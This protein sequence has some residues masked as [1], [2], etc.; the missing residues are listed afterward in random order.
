MIALL[1]ENA[2]TQNRTY[3]YSFFYDDCATRPRDKVEESMLGEVVYPTLSSDSKPKT[4]RDIIYESTINNLWARFGMDFCVGSEADRPITDRQLMFA[5][6]YLMNAFEGAQIATDS[7]SR[8][9]VSKKSQLIFADKE[10]LEYT[11]S[12][13]LIDIF[14]PMRCALILFIIVTLLTIYGIKNK[15]GLWGLDL[16]RFAVAG[17]SGGVIAFLA[18]VSSH[19]AV[20]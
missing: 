20:T 1:E 9:L 3:R 16:I 6:F 4:F 5:P 8:P 10:N 13:R 17:I 2:L 11:W 15:K 18:F 12:D 14:S 19:P 7:L